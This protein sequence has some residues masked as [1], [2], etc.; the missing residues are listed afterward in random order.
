LQLKSD[1]GQ[2]S[3]KLHKNGQRFLGIHIALTTTNY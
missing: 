1:G 2:Q 3:K